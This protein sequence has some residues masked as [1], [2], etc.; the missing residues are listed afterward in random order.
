[1][2]CAGKKKS[3]IGLCGFVFDVQN[4]NGGGDLKVRWKGVGAKD[5]RDNGAV[6]VE[7]V[8]SHLG[9]EGGKRDDN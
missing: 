6:L 4:I 9:Q 2:F 1:V 5:P 3:Q 7:S 8:K